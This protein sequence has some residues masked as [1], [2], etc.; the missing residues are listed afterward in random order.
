MSIVSLAEFVSS[1]IILSLALII[2]RRNPYDNFY[3]L[4]SA[5]LVVLFAAIFCEY[6]ISISQ[7]LEEARIL[8]KFTDVFWLF[9]TALLLHA[10]MHFQGSPFLARGFNFFLIYLPQVV[11]SII[12]LSTDI[13]YANFIDTALGIFY[14]HNFY[15]YVLV[16]VNMV[17][18]LA[19][20]FLCFRTWQ[21]SENALIK[22]QAYFIG[23]ISS[24]PLL[25]GIGILVLPAFFKLVSPSLIGLSCAIAVILGAAA[26]RRYH[27]FPKY[28]EMA[29]ENIFNFLPDILI[30]TDLSNCVSLVSR[31]FLQLCGCNCAAELT[32]KPF[33]EVIKDKGVAGFLFT[34]VMQDNR[35]I[36]DCPLVM[37]KKIFSLNSAPIFD[38]T[39][40]KIGM[41]TIGRDVTERKKNESEL[42]KSTE[43]LEANLVE[44]DRLNRAFTQRELEMS[45]IKAEI[46]G[47]K[48]K[49][50]E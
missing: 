20:I 2:F 36:R 8:S 43:T 41:V 29:G 12:T 5:A 48:I 37:G 19:A 34:S 27:L 28:P 13:T 10:V 25:S 21:L 31:S 4:F 11:L 14:V 18:L 42:K 22:K 7:L 17:Y 6:R 3:K 38:N 30:V 1:I 35:R 24:L 44:I 26:E 16:F 47:L 40:D 45:Q 33:A 46:K 23:L 49:L 15:Y 32:G 9:A 39:N 50:H